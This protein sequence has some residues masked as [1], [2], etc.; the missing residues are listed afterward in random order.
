MLPGASGPSQDR[1]LE[2][3]Q[4]GQ[5]RIAGLEAEE[6][7]PPPPPPPHTATKKKVRSNHEDGHSPYSLVG[8]KT[9]MEPEDRVR[10]DGERAV[11]KA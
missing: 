8:Q 4:W 5:L 6:T 3:E 2:E 9:E 7:P 11:R 1:G 10:L